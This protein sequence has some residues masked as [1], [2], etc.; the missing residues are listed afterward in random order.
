[1]TAKLKVG[2][3]AWLAEEKQ[4]ASLIGDQAAK[5]ERLGFHS[6]WLPENHFGKKNSLPAPLLLLAAAAARTDKIKLGT[7]SYLLPIR[8]PIQMAEEV[9]VLDQLSEGRVIL[10][11]GRGYQTGMFEVFQIPVGEKRQRF[12]KA[13]ETMIT[14]W[15]GQA[16]GYDTPSEGSTQRSAIYLSPKPYQKPHPPVW[17]AAFGPKALQQAGR[18]GLP[19]LASPVETMASLKEKY[20]MYRAA[21]EETG[22]KKINTVPIMR[23][24]F[25]SR[26]KSYL[27]KVRAWLI[28]EAAELSRSPIASIRGSADQSPDDWTIVG[29]PHEVQD[30]IMKYQEY[31]GMTHLIATK[32]R[33]GSIST[34]EMQTSIELLA[35]IVQNTSS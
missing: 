24:V 17:V 9:S 2:V 16:V 27:K 11:V 20:D 8:N 10:G 28:N 21:C 26:E 4:T 29:E 23:T 15:E 33:L 18:L 6:F 19:Y 22:G 7:G 14:A 25:V 5:M 12:E 3:G 30:K 1:M 32:G 31:L 13:L 34:V 35:E